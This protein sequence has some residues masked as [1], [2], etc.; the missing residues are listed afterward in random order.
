VNRGFLVTNDD[1]KIWHYNGRYW[2]NDGEEAIRNIVQKVLGSQCTKR[3]KDEIISWIKDCT[4]I[5]VDRK[6]FDA[7]PNLIPCKNGIFDISTM[8][9]KGYDQYV[10]WPIMTSFLPV[11]YEPT[12]DCPNFKKFLEDVL[13]IEDLPFIQEFVGY[14]LY[15]KPTWAILVIL[16]GHGRNGKTTF[17]NTLT[18]LLGEDNIEHIPL[19]HLAKDI[20][21]RSRLFGKW[22][23]LCADIGEEE[24]KKTGLVKELTGG[25]PI[26]ARDLYQSGFNFI[27]YAKLLFGC[28]ILPICKDNSLAMK[29]RYAIIEFPN[30]FLRDSPECD[31]FILD[32][33][34]TDTE[35]SGILNWAIEGL[36]RLLKNKT[37]SKYRDLEDVSKYLAENKN[38]VKKFVDSYI[39]YAFDSE[40]V[41]DTVYQAFLKFARENGHPTMYSNH[42]SST[43]K[44]F[45]PHGMSEGQSRA[46]NRKKV[47][48]GIK[49]KD[50]IL[51]EDLQEKLICST[52][53]GVNDVND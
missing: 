30:Q 3:R 35:L 15:R 48:I 32:K 45:A 53:E 11:S 14:C 10:G 12:M 43:F 23:N 34:T 22:A 6:L 25:D 1:K 7:E 47:W 52:E 39:E 16:L 19:Q 38:P 20:F 50:S 33:L 29:E 44:L 13:Y 37:F 17:I 5:Q 18:A 28:N 8:E 31:P 9:F 40:L 51:Q 46:V 42:F 49:F 36:Q 21:A 27:N 4:E 26:F 24:I 41:K 2:E